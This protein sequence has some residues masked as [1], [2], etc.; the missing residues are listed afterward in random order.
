[1]SE[2]PV[3]V[4]QTFE[5]MNMASQEAA[6]RWIGIHSIEASKRGGTWP[7]LSTTEVG[8][9]AGLLLEVW[10][11]RPISEGEPRWSLVWDDRP[12]NAP[13]AP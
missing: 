8:G 9:V 2:A 4:A 7:R 3:Y 10:S 5:P 13:P 12:N 11:S 1:M 6:G